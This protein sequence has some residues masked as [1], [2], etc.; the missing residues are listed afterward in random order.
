MKP[1]RERENEPSEKKRLFEDVR[2]TIK[3]VVPGAD[4]VY[5]GSRGGEDDEEPLKMNFLV[6]IDQ[7]LDRDVTMKITDLLYRCGSTANVAI[8]SVVVTKESWNSPHYP[9]REFKVMVEEEGVSL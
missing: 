8:G 4:I 2:M 5:F 3:G 9:D 1:Y 7:P 6:L